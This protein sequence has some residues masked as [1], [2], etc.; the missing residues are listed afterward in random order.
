MIDFR[1][2][3]KCLW[4]SFSAVINE[5]E[6]CG[7]DSPLHEADRG[8]RIS[9]YDR[10]GRMWGEMLRPESDPLHVAPNSGPRD[11]ENAGDM[12]GRLARLDHAA[13]SRSVVMAVGIVAT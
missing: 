10:F 13:S 2:V 5:A 7:N 6:S 9:S 8:G 3:E 12:R 1:Y 11:V 4:K